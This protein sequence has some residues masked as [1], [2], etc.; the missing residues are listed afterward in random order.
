MISVYLPLPLFF[1]ISTVTIYFKPYELNNIYTFM[2]F[3]L[4]MSLANYLILFL[5]FIY[6]FN[7]HKPLIN[8]FFI[9]LFFIVVT[10]NRLRICKNKTTIAKNFNK[11][12]Y[13]L[14]DGFIQVHPPIFYLSIILFFCILFFRIFVST[15]RYILLL[16]VKFMIILVIAAV[17]TGGY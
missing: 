1:I 5:A 12:T 9:Q 8:I 3:L 4:N 16:F 13:S 2:I 14:V 10:K 15:Q 17:F 7:R 6:M 11:Q